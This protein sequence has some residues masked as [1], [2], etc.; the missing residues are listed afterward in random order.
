[1]QRLMLATMAVAIFAGTLWVTAAQQPANP[2]PGA[3]RGQGPGRAGGPP[4][5]PAAPA[6]P[7]GPLVT[8]TPVTDAMLRDPSPNDWLMWRRTFNAWGHS[9][10]NQITRNN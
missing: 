1:M 10:L 4:A 9:P 2:Q 6:A 5:A 7:Q 3:A 8:F